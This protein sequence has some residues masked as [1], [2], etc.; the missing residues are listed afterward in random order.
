MSKNADMILLYAVEE[1][2]GIGYK[3]DLLV[4]ISEDLKDFKKLT[5]GNIIIMGRKTFESLPNS[6]ALPNRLNIVI[7]KDESYSREGIKVVH[8]IEGL[9]ELLKE[10]DP[11]NEKTRY[12]IG[13]GSIGSQLLPYCNLGYITKIFKSFEN[14][15]TILPNLDL[16]DDWEIARESSVR[17]QDDLEYKYVEYRRKG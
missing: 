17:K 7:T 15:D 5:T 3:N 8:S 1:N 9:F 2:W 11:N 6:K 10:V 16:H 12:V 13:G 4:K 14:I